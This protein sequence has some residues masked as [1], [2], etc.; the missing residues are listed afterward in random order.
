MHEIETRVKRL[1]S[2]VCDIPIEQI[3]AESSSKNTDKWDSINLINLMLSVE[4]E[5]GITMDVD[6]A[7]ELNSVKSIIDIVS[8]KL[9]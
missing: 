1:I 5:F 6:Q 8:K 9:S 4:T 3:T 7:M 2:D